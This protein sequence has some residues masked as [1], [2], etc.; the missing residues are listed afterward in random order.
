MQPRD[1]RASVQ[2]R[3]RARPTGGRRWGAA[4]RPLW[5][6]RFPVQPSS[7]VMTQQRPAQR[8]RL[9]PVRGSLRTLVR[10][11]RGARP[12]RKP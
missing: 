4:Q 7:R 8:S 5:H 6:H 11:S 3:C 9:M 10:G 12:G 2:P 1:Q